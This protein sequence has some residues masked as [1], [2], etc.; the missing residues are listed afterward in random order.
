MYTNALINETSPYLLQ[1]AHNPVDWY[2]WGKEALDKAK[3]ENKML[4]ISVGYAACHWCHV[5]EHE[6][7]EDTT[8]ANIM[9]KNFV[10]I[11]VD[12][13]ERP[14][15]DQVYMNAAYL[16][17][18]NGGWPL[19][20]LAMPDGKPFFAGTYYPKDTWIKV[21]DYFADL[22]K[23]DRK[24]LDDEANN[25]AKGIRDIENVP[26]NKGHVEFNMD[27]LN[28]M[29]STLDQKID[30]IKGGTKGAMKF[31]MPSMWE[32]LLGYHYLSG[33][34]EALQAVETTLNQM[35]GGGIYDQVGGG[36]SRYATDA[37]WHAPHFE[38]M[39][40]DNA[41][42]VSLYSHAFQVTKNPL[43]KRI[44]YETISFVR[45]EL[46]SPQGGFYSS[47]DA[48][49]EG[50]EGKF[51]VWSYQ[52]IKDIL[53]NDAGIFSEYFS[54]TEAGNWED[55]QNIPDINMGDKNTAKKYHL[56]DDQLQKKINEL[57]LKLF[58][59]REKRIRPHTD[60]KILTSW[61]A[62]MSKGL[63]DAYE[64][65]G[66][67][68]FMEMANAN[69]NFILN[70]ISSKENGLFRN[71]KN[72]K[73]TIPAFLDDYAFTISALIDYYQVNFDEKYLKKANE[74]TQ[75]VEDH[76][77]DKA[78]GMFFYTDDQYSNL[79]A[80]KMEV[81]DNV[82]PSSNSEMAKNLLLL[83][84]YFENKTYETQSRQF[85]K[86][87]IEDIKKNVAYYSNWAQVMA[88]QIKYPYEIA[89][90]GNNWK[91]K[92]LQFHEHYLPNSIFVGGKTEGNFSLLE[93]KLV[94]GKTMIYVCENQT[95]QRPVEDV[96]DALKQIK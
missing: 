92:L 41:Q 27:T 16:I 30:K 24:K 87:V 32:Y 19:N 53:G 8:V 36:F 75:Y 11:K 17:N 80:R 67:S 78:S 85:V 23:T 59:A 49:S 79:I 77:F 72:G 1:H 3:K 37:N 20:A 18:G 81:S 90:V 7:Y 28:D 51:Y 93:N 65:F 6:S 95:C 44:V 26:L 70:H 4:L 38:K 55:H 45:R 12:R 25:L 60:D 50:K 68:N 9:N 34:K 56:T 54:I 31:P 2:P 5:M 89:V 76:F 22:Y 69:I 61:N 88:L 91:E 47:L 13:E 39:L 42:L 52:E 86:N 84:L 40:Y 46:T 21:L 48:D 74:L 94:K 33:N 15:V 63:I 58:H 62:L 83:G 66:D 43:Y 96:E 57:K 64:A 73:A 82:I 29:F 71:Y 35:A 14:D 10:C